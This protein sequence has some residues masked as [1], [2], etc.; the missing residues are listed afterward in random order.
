[1]RS[2]ELFR[3]ADSRNHKPQ[4]NGFVCRDVVR[5]RSE[6]AGSVLVIIDRPYLYQKPFFVHRA[7]KLGR[8]VAVVKIDSDGAQRGGFFSQRLRV[9]VPGQ[10][11]V[12]VIGDVRAGPRRVGYVVFKKSRKKYLLQHARILGHGLHLFNKC[13]AFYVH[14]RLDARVHRQKR[15]GVGKRSTFAVPGSVVR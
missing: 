7:Y 12:Q 10:T 15:E 3:Q 14:V 6:G 11:D 9:F 2:I 4:Q 8:Y 13:R 5:P 1:M